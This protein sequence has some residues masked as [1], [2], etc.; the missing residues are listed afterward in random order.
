MTDAISVEGVSKT[1]RLW[2]ER[3]D[4]LKGFLLRRR[5]GRWEDLK[6]LDTVSFN[7]P[8]GSTFGLLGSNGAGKSTTLKL[9]ARIIVPD[10]GT[11]TVNGKV[12]ALLELGAG[13]HPELSGRE[14][15]FLNGAILGLSRKMLRTRF[16]EIVE[17]AG[18]TE[19]ID[20]QVKTYSSGMFARLGFAVAVNVDPDVLLIDEVLAVGDAEFQRKCHMKIADLRSA[21]RT[22][23]LVTHDLNV[24]RDLCERVAWIDHGRVRDVGPAKSIVE[25]YLSS[26]HPDVVVD[27]H[28][29]MRT[30]T[31]RLRIDRV[32]VCGPRD[33][34][35]VVT[36]QPYR[37]LF[38]VGS[39]P[40]PADLVLRVDIRRADGLLVAGSG[41]I[42]LG[43][44]DEPR[45]LGLT[46]EY[47]G[48]SFS[49]LP[50]S[51]AL[52]TSLFDHRRGEL[53]DEVEQLTFDVAPGGE[54][55]AT[56]VV[57]L[58]GAWRVT[59]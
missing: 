26:V 46:I 3:N 23:V 52:T 8:A 50:D 14:N 31:G 35:Q 39:I 59:A 30:G 42:P 18:L 28:G 27:D 12:S 47:S 9:L 38:R 54:D 19:F 41:T 32:D 13:F 5:A 17:F 25:A 4:S 22:V 40:E 24:V 53:L 36:G 49:L 6:V 1:Y 44:L 56:G 48:S 21:G 43:T 10:E 45:P 57:S 15:I 29:R 51:Y 58:G 20:N 7:V 16:E 2:H 55:G 11:I 34:G 37:L 33:G